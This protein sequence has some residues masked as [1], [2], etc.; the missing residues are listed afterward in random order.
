MTITI[1]TLFV[2]IALFIWGRVRSD[3]VAM[4]ALMV[5]TA[6]G[7]LTTQEAL[8]GFSS[9]IVIIVTNIFFVFLFFGVDIYFLCDFIFQCV[10][11]L[12]FEFFFL[13]EELVF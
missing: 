8:S 13:A 6:T 12:D 2:T 5:L 7:I 9:P 11:F 3:I 10:N 1:I 4:A